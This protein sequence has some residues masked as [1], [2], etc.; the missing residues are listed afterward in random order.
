M[1]LSLRYKAAILIALTE[2]LLLGLLLFS[3]LHN[4]SQNL[5]KQLKTQA[6]A[7][8]E[9]VA[10]SATEPLLAFDLARLRSLVKGVIDKHNVKHVA[11]VDHQD[12]VLAEAG[13]SIDP[14]QSVSAQ[15]PILVAGS[16]FGRVRLEISRVEA[17]AALA[18]TTQL[19]IMIVASEILLVAIISL[20]LGWFL[21]RNLLQLTRGIE[22]VE[23]GDLATRVPIDSKDE[24]G[25]LATQ[26]NRMAEHLQNNVVELEEVNRRFRDMADNIN[27]WIWEIDLNGYHT[28][29]SKRVEHLLGYT[30]EQAKGL[31]AFTLMHKEDGRRF[32]TLMSEARANKKPFYGF[33]YRATSKDGSEVVLEANGA[34]ILDRDG[35]LVGFRGVTRDITRRK[36]DASRLIYLSEHDPLTGLIGRSRFLEILDDT[37]KVSSHSRTPIAILIVDLDDFKMI[38][39]SHGH[40]AGD[41]MLRL[42]ADTLMRLCDD[43]TPVARIGGD[44]FGI[45]LRG[46]DS[47]DAKLLAK[48]ILNDLR[49]VRATIG[50]STMHLSA[51]VGICC[52]PADGDD[53][54]TLLSRADIAMT[55]AKS[56]GHSSYYIFRSTDRDID[57]IR[58]TVNWR[59]Q[60]HDALEHNRLLLE[61]QPILS[62]QPGA[63]HSMFEALIRLRDEDG[64][65]FPAAQFILTAEQSGQISDIDRWVLRNV[66]DVLSK[67]ENRHHT[68]AVNL[69]GRSLSTPGF[70]E[71][72]QKLT[73]ESSINPSSLIFEITETTAIGEMA[74]A[75]NFITIMKRLGYRFSLDDF[76]VGYSSFSYLKHFPVDQLKIDGSFVRHLDTSRADQIFVRAIVQVAQELGLET[77]AEFVENEEVFNLLKEIGVDNV[78]GY[79]IGKPNSVFYHPNMSE[80][81]NKNTV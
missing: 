31:S 19:N 8:A 4:T 76:G 45:M 41:T 54:Q 27:D 51:G 28:Y 18:K 33:E 66:I 69:S 10:S 43:V 58:H 42:A 77:I 25:Q 79:Y 64:T 32:R 23:Q 78:Q 17:D 5:E 44:E 71:Y 26:F 49:A 52:Y 70:C 56:L 30:P 9:L 15:H 7:T 35:E 24:V 40:L 39:D 59:R 12:Q 80:N 22:A 38:N 11:I 34:P 37:L 46:A 81:Q 68:V 67:P 55:H 2:G 16:L 72:C 21:T 65:I 6:R 48:R 74:R 36:E 47:E 73:F 61:F 1:K 29:A 20:T 14:R 57:A 13:E 50:D 62:L 75:E 3:N 63:M 60:I 53:S